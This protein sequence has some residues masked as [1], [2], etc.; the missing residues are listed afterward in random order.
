MRRSDVSVAANI[1]EGSARENR[2]EYMQFLYIAMA[3]LAELSYYIRF[4]KEL[5]YLDTKTHE[6]LWTKAQEGTGRMSFFS[7]RQKAGER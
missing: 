2:N 4:T 7:I 6:E 5:E 3:S 1:V